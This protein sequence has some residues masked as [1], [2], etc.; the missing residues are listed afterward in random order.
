MVHLR[1]HTGER[2]YLVRFLS[3]HR[4]NPPLL[5]MTTLPKY[6]SVSSRW[7][8]IAIQHSRV[9]PFSPTTDSPHHFATYFH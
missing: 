3:F 9:Q 8:Y 6:S 5:T 2:P 4:R 1:L 7:L